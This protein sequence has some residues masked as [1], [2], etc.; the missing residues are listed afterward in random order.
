MYSK[1]GGG[2]PHGVIEADHALQFNVPHFEP[3]TA[4]YLAGAKRCH[5]RGAQLRDLTGGLRQSIERNARVQMMDVVVADIR[6]EPR[7]QSAGLH[8]ARGFDRRLV[9]GPAG[10]V[11]EGDAGKIVLRVKEIRPERVEDE[12]P[13]WL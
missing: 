2:L 1:G 12:V 7:H 6:R 13:D 3:E 9:V 4:K 11:I 8:K 10:L 5:P